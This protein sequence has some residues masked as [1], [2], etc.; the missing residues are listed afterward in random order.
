[1]DFEFKT[2]KEFWGKYGDAILDVRGM[3]LA[4]PEYDHDNPAHRSRNA[5]AREIAKQRIPAQ[6]CKIDYT[7]IVSGGAYTDGFISFAHLETYFPTALFYNV[8]RG[9]YE[10]NEIGLKTGM[11]TQGATHCHHFQWSDENAQAIAD[12][13]ESAGFMVAFCNFHRDTI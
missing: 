3:V 12:V 1:M 13:L 8:V 5:K 10:P 6:V 11:Y 9:K 2:E 7:R 4:Y